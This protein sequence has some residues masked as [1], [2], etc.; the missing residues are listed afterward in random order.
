MAQNALLYNLQRFSNLKLEK[1]TKPW[2]QKYNYPLI[3][4]LSR[5]LAVSFL[6]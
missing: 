4:L 5:R 1:Q 3:S 2:L 6:D